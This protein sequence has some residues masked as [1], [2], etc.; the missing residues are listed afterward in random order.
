MQDMLIAKTF[1]VQT[2][3]FTYPAKFIAPVWAQ[4]FEC[5]SGLCGLC[6]LVQLPDDVPRKHN[7]K[8]DRVV[9]R[10]YDVEQRLCLR[11]N[12]RPIGCKI[13]PFLFGVEE[14]QIIIS[15]S[16]ECPATNL[17]KNIQTGI[18]VNVL[19]DAHVNQRIT[20]MNDCYE[21]AILLPQIWSD[22][23]RVWKT[24]TNMVQDYFRHKTKFPFL[25][26]FR[27]LSVKTVANSL[28][29]EVPE[30]PK[31]S[32]SVTKL[33]ESTS[34]LYIGTRFES[35]NLCLVKVKGNKTKITVFDQNLKELNKVKMKTP[36]KFLDLEIDKEAQHLLND[37]VSFLC[38]RPFLSLA[39]IFSNKNDPRPIPF[40]LES[41]LAGSLMIVE[42]GATLLASRDKLKSIDRDTMREIISYSEGS[43]QPMFSNPD[44]VVHASLS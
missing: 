40:I 35:N 3:F 11:Y 16:L 23:N 39:T 14:G 18:L 9:C 5:K 10:F 4:G 15:A 7:A 42:V 43:I 28:N 1:N 25:L 22:A 24:L 38:H 32:Y 30:V 2:P 29:L 44:K 37:Y 21:K 31:T 27:I 26:D 19:E 36:R 41:T 20:I 12:K 8:M 13:Y 6:C 34:G 17:K 33:I